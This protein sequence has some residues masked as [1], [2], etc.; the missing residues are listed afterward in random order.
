MDKKNLVFVLVI[1]CAHYLS[2]CSFM[3][4]STLPK[5]SHYNLSFTKDEWSPIDPDSSDLAYRNRQT[6]STLVLNSQCKKYDSASLE[7]VSATLLNGIAQLDIMDKHN[8]EFAGREAQ[9]TTATGTLDGVPI[10]LKGM[11]L[12]KDGCLYDLI[13][14]SSGRD[15][16]KADSLAFDEFIK[17]FRP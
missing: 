1:L 10:F 4:S 5:S 6:S 3:S 7:T 15:Q 17:G 12:K 16:L 2:A 14:I 13:L 8:I 9:I 11:V